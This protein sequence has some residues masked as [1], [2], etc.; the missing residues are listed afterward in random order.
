MRRLL[1]YERALIDA[2][3][4]SEEEYWQFYLARLNYRDNK[5]GTILDVRN[6][7]DPGTVALI[8]TIVGTLAQVGAALLAPKPEAPSATMGRRSRNLFFAP[9]YGFNSFQEVAR[10]GD[11]VNLVYTN[12]SENPAGGVRV[13]T[14][15]V[16]SA[17]HSL[18]SRQFMQMLAVVGAGPIEEFGYGR[19]AFGQTPLRDIPAQRFWLYAQPD[20]GRLAFIHNRY[21][22][23][24]NADD[25]S[26]EGITPTDAVYKTNTSGLQRPEGFSQAF[27]PTTA[28]SLGVYDVVPIRVQVEDRNDNGEEERDQLGVNLTGRGSFWPDTWPAVGVRPAL[29]ANSELTI[30]FRED[31]GKSV[32]EDVERAAV[33]LRSSYI[34]V[35]DSS[36]LYKLGAA[37]LKMISSNINNGSDVEGRFTFKCVEPGVLCEEDY[38]TLNYQQNGE[39]L[40][41]RKKELEALIAQLNS[42]YGVAFGN[43]ISGAAAAQ[44]DQYSTR[45]EQL[46]ENIL[47]ASAIRKGDISSKDFRDLLDETGAFQEAN[48]DINTLEEEFK[49]LS[50]HKENL[51]DIINNI[52]EIR[53]AD[54]TDA[55]KDRLRTAKAEK[56]QAIIDRNEKRKQ[57]NNLV[58]R[59]MPKA[60]LEGLFVDAPNTNLRDELRAMRKE[61]RQIRR[62]IDELVRNQ[63]DTVA[64][65]AAQQDWQ[66]RYDEAARELRETEAELKN[67]DNWNDYFN[68]KCIAKI[69]EI[70]YEATTKCDIVNFCFK[71]KIFQRIQ[72]RQSVYAE[73][74][75]QGHKD[76][77]N[78]VRNRT[79]MFWMLYKKPTDTRYTRA[80][81]VLAIRN[82]KEVDIYTHLRF[83]AASKEKWQFKFEPIVDL[84]AELR[85]HNDAQQINM[86]YLR[87]FGYGLN[88]EQN[89]VSLDGGHQLVFRGKIRQTVRLRP[90]LNRTPKFV[91][92]WGL[93]SLRSDTQISF[94]FDSGP[95]NSLVAVTEQQLE[96]FSPNLYQDLVLLG[97]NIYSGQG[98]QD[99]RSLSAWVT[100]GKKVR[101]LSDGGSYSSSLVSSTS[102]A[103][104][105]FLDTILDEKN[106]IGAYANVN[107]IDTARLGLAQKFCRANGY[108]MDGV[109]AEPQSWREF[110]ST[111]APFSLLEFARIG[112]KETL[113]PAVPYDTFGNVTRN[114]SISALFN[115]GNI[116]EDSYKEEFLDY[117]DNTQD[118]I[119]TIVYR[120]TENDNVFPGNT[121]LTIMLADASESNSVRQTFN[122]SDF[123]TRRVQAL[124]YGML[125]CQQRR[126]SRRAVEF[127]TFPT[128]SPI[129]PGSYV[130]VQTDQNQWDDFRSG[131]VEAN[132]KLNTPLAE[133]PINGSY[134]ALLYSGSPN[135][136]IV[137]LSVSVTD[138]QSASL[139]PYEGWLFVLGNAVTTKR[140]FRVTEVT[141][142]EEGEITVRAIEHPCEEQGGQ[143]KSKIVRFDPSLYRID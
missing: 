82:G 123:V 40:R 75:M 129:E 23:P 31:D 125:L 3:Q 44:I 79:S 70:S 24:L 45:L 109:I 30:I 112:G 101:K 99:L 19:T 130:Y 66:R 38:G 43:K 39:E 10:Y 132:G 115:Q 107:G 95:E 42:E 92:E 105:I 2:L 90:R 93:F 33:D 81:F 12:N 49:T 16:W 71:S 103:P 63:R 37:K 57:I 104:E 14:S 91:D 142:E 28:T 87:T 58:R 84:P 139:A 137:K 18:G 96:S 121:S 72:G 65:G 83:I 133:D 54:R 85:T 21:P 140:V 120:N 11:P 27:S 7:I 128:E 74:D 5:E 86:L 136:G 114:I 131:I 8:L 34:T 118:L 141:M 4:I 48:R 110:W 22:E 80:K 102:Y 32:G 113:V 127:K 97:L 51:Q 35:F 50:E 89:S 78:G 56:R 1:P 126:L 138:S 134:T 106:G 62:A 94:S 143:T 36:S 47:R 111:V 61:R 122:L 69:D 73:T 41:A 64:E 53:P 100:K 124:H 15:L 116:L 68:T 46:D 88:D 108:Y 67:P 17:V 6:G 117:G 77:D 55:Q 98:V 135:E 76:S 60:I 25:P 20:G 29:P 119:A 9:R 52:L 26:R 13:N 59:L